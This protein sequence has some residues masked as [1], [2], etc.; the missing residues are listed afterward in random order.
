[1]TEQHGTGENRAQGVRN[2]LAG[3]VRGRTVDWF[4]EADSAADA[5]RGKQ[6]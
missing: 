2:S 5:G 1:M 3:D 4:V 6:A